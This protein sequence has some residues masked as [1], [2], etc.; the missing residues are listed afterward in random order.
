MSLYFIF[1]I[2]NRI[3]SCKNSAQFDAASNLYRIEGS[4]GATF[5]GLDETV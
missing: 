1:Y 5:E 4:V 3:M 2:S